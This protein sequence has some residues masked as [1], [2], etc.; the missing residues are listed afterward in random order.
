MNTTLAPGQPFSGTL[1]TFVDND[2]GALA[3]DYIATTNW[4]DGTTTTSTIQPDP[5]GIGYDVV[6]SHTY[7][8]AGHYSVRIF[9]QTYDG[10]GAQVDDQINVKGG[11]LNLSFVDNPAANVNQTTLNTVYGANPFLERS[12][13]PVSDQPPAPGAQDEF[14]SHRASCWGKG[15]RRRGPSETGPSGSRSS[16]MTV[17]SGL[18]S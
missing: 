4:G 10:A 11:R 9:I 12:T 17:A 5:S 8:W 14:N 1:A 6:D 7:R 13:T 3:R 2:P 16:L 15:E 18:L